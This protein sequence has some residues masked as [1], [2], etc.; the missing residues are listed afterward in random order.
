MALTK[1]QKQAIINEYKTNPNDTGSIEVQVA[2]LTYE[3][4][5]LNQHLKVHAKDFHSK[6]GLF[7]KIGHRRSLLK[8]L[9][10]E[11]LDRYQ[12]LIARLGLRR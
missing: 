12:A 10:D 9:K 6:R 7:V 2:I 4:N 8:Y 5:N 1:E 3:I 11:D